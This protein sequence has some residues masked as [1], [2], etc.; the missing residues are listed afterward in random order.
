MSLFGLLA[1]WQ[2]RRHLTPV[3]DQLN[4]VPV[5]IAY[6]MER[7]VPINLATIENGSRVLL[8]L[9]GYA[10]LSDIAENSDQGRRI[11]RIRSRQPRSEDVSDDCFGVPGW[12]MMR[13]EE[14][15][16]ELVGGQETQIPG[17]EECHSRR[18][19]I[20]HGACILVHCYMD[21]AVVHYDLSP[22]AV[23]GNMRPRKSSFIISSCICS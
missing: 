12:K 19:V 1:R 18:D 15:V 4:D 10:C 9:I 17:I 13:L 23:S 20:K 22:H 7:P 14:S 5:F 6:W 2:V 8:C 3:K 11:C 16:E 21:L